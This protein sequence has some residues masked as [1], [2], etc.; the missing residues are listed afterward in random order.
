VSAFQ[1]ANWN[2]RDIAAAWQT[3]NADLNPRLRGFSAF[4]DAFNVRAGSSAYYEISGTGRP[5]TAIRFRDGS[6]GPLPSFVTV[7]AVRVQ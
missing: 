6:S 4:T 3:P 7:W 5:A 1:Y 2:L